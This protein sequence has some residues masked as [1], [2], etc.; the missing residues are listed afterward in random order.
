MCKAWQI[1][2]GFVSLACPGALYQVLRSTAGCVQKEE[3]EL[4]RLREQ[5]RIRAGKELLA[6]KKLEDD[7]RLKRNLEERRR[8][9]EEEARAKERIRLKLGGVPSD[10]RQSHLGDCSDAA[11]TLYVADGRVINGKF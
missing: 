5:E 3:R 6:A 4:E 1:F 7:L 10:P 11:V 9:K 2:I 8:E